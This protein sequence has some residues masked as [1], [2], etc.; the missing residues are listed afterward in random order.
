[1]FLRSGVS[2]QPEICCLIRVILR[3]QSECI[4]APGLATGSMSHPAR[5]DPNHKLYTVDT[6]TGQH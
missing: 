5:S 4:L 6:H 1:M 3:L 2:E